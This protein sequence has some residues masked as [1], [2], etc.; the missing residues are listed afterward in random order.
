MGAT[1]KILT[2][3]IFLLYSYIVL[4]FPPELKFRNIST[5]EG[6]SHNHVTA[7]IKDYKGFIWFGTSGSLNKYDGYRFTVYSKVY[8]DSSSLSN[9]IISC[10]FEDKEKRLWIGTADGLNLYNRLQD[11]FTRF[12]NDEKKAGSISKGPITAIY[13]DRVGN[14]WIGTTGGLNLFEARTKTFKIFR[15]NQ[16]NANSIS[17]DIVTSIAE[18]AG[19]NLWVGTM[20]GLNRLLDIKT[21]SFITYAST[22]NPVFRYDNNIS[23]LKQ[24]KQGNLWV[25]MRNNGLHALKT[26]NNSYSLKHI[27]FSSDKKFDL[28]TLDILNLWIENDI[29]WIGTEN[30]GLFLYDTK[31]GLAVNYKNQPDDEQSLSNNSI[32]Y[33]FKSDENIFWLSS[34]NKGI[35]CYDPNYSL[36]NGL[37]VKKNHRALNSNNVTGFS[38]DR[39]GNLWISTDGGGLNYWNRK[40]NSFE[41]YN[42]TNRTLPVDAAMCVLVDSKGNTWCGT[43]GG[44]LCYKKKDGRFTCFPESNNDGY[45]HGNKI[46]SLSEDKKGRIWVGTIG[47]GIYYYSE[48]DKKFILIFENNYELRYS[49]IWSQMHTADSSIWLCS[50][51]GVFVLKEKNNSKFVIK[52]YL[53]DPKNDKSLS[54]NQTRSLLQDRKGNIWIG[55]DGG[56]LNKFDPATETFT[57]ILKSDGLPDNSIKSM[58]DDGYGNIWIATNKGLCKYTPDK[59]LFRNYDSKDG[60]YSDLFSFGAI[61]QSA[62]GEIFL[63]SYNGF[64]YFNPQNIKDNPHVPPVYIVDLKVNNEAVSVGKNSPLTQSISETKKITFNYKQNVFTFEFAALNY[65]HPEKNQ[66]AYILEGFDERWNYTGNLHSAT[67]TNL[68]PGQYRFKVRGSNNHGLWSPTP[69]SIEIE[70]LPPFW[71]SKLAIFIYFIIILGLLYFFIAFKIARSRE[72]D[73]IKLEL[74]K[75][76]QEEELYKNKLQFLTVISHELRTPLT[77][78][79]SPLEQ[80]I[81]NEGFSG[82]VKEKLKIV[83]RNTQRLYRL[84]DELIDFSRMENQKTKLN[85]VNSNIVQYLSNIKEYFNDLALER[86][87]AF[88]FE[89]DNNPIFMGFDREKLD[90]V[91]FNLLINAFKFSPDGGSI[92]I[93]LTSFKK[94]TPEWKT[95][96]AALHEFKNKDVSFV[97]ISVTDTGIGI[98]ADQQERVFESFYQV[99]DQRI[100]SSG[101]GIGL[102]LAKSIVELHGGAIRLVSQ[103]EK[104]STFKVFLPIE[105]TQHEKTSDDQDEILPRIIPDF[106]SADIN[107]PNEVSIQHEEESATKFTILLVEDNI[108]LR[109]YLKAELK[110]EFKVL[111]ATSGNEGLNMLL[112]K[113]PDLV[114]SDIIMPDGDGLEFCS[115]IKKNDKINHIPVILLTAKNSPEEKLTGIETGADAYITKPFNIEL[116]KAQINQILLNRKLLISK[117]ASSQ[118]IIYNSN[119]TNGEQQFMESLKAILTK[120]LSDPDLSVEYLAS[121][122]NLSRSQIY[123]KVK[124]ITNLSPNDYIKAIRLETAKKILE[125]QAVTIVEAAIQVGFTS[126]SY[127]TKCFKDA[128]GMLPND[129]V[130]KKKSE[131][132]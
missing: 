30:S 100:N 35:D 16:N 128:F 125:T 73:R 41:Y 101:T 37:Q 11:N 32:W 15:H 88:S 91:F 17:H 116:L 47:G 24:D 48:N 124:S 132:H 94:D 79:V 23:H 80:I 53:H 76:E 57:K 22:S 25:S 44:G 105:R 121:A 103:P 70:V 42:S 123:R 7:I 115:K 27:T 118:Q 54:D 90:K 104:G 127:F 31:S 66:Y 96:I 40:K 86:K 78:I 102:T 99:R 113:L 18:D 58:I 4:P 64:N 71:K 2:S 10:I 3:I 61:L 111:E 46:I 5:N 120:N 84:I 98:S 130:I 129:L 43:W 39:A 13:Q 63:G 20:R 34:Y 52:H 12:F 106:Y 65:S 51:N 69:A 87:M 14:I 56:G 60:L 97:L 50:S 9:N 95:E 85:P 8:N 131:V 55:T 109:K 75:V 21:G 33:I 119:I 68:K 82:A 126:P 77:L 117:L 114:L 112:N 89:Y 1:K 59:M 28:S 92:S 49:N 26:E 38:E 83:Y 19:G 72:K 93:K 81:G 45:L 108:E 67:Y 6:L 29:I 62:Q 110:G 122:L 36:F 74:L 107:E